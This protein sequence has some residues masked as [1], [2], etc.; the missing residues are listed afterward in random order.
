MTVNF[1]RRHL[2]GVD[3]LR[4][5]NTPL[6]FCFNLFFY[7]ITKFPAIPKNTQRHITR[8]QTHNSLNY[9]KQWLSSIK[10]Q[11]STKVMRR[12]NYHRSVCRL[13][14]SRHESNLKAGVQ[15]FVFFRRSRCISIGSLKYLN[16]QNY[17]LLE[18]VSLHRFPQLAIRLH[19]VF[20]DVTGA[21]GCKIQLKFNNHSS[22]SQASDQKC[23]LQG[24][25]LVIVFV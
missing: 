17:L 1:F 3:E 23:H 4:R 21:W 6:I 20:L 5:K 24:A 8:V 25:A 19:S 16:M 11:Y 7:H 14:P 10:Y 15:F 2:G 13:Y 12:K 22:S 9:C 18:L